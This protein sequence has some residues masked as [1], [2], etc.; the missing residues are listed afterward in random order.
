MLKGYIVRKNQTFQDNPQIHNNFG[1]R[2]NSSY[3]SK[4]KLPLEQIAQI[5]HKSI[6]Q[7]LFKFSTLLLPLFVAPS[8]SE[9]F[10]IPICLIKKCL[11]IRV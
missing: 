7:G 3:M 11:L 1:E 6:I 8:N 10:P 2:K 5:Q 4:R 9:W